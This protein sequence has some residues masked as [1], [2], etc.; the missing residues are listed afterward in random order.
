MG[1]VYCCLLGRGVPYVLG[2]VGGDNEGCPRC[3]VLE[4]RCTEMQWAS[5]V[6]GNEK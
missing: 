2:P 6:Q 4:R 3:Q 5:E 1:S